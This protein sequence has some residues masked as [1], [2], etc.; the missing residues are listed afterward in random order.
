MNGCM[1]PWAGYLAKKLD[2]GVGRELELTREVLLQL[3]L[4]SKRAE[5][6]GTWAREAKLDSTG[7]GA[8]GEHL[9]CARH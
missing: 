1:N 5:Q 7:E 8:S 4:N 9:L 6:P 3:G 2:K